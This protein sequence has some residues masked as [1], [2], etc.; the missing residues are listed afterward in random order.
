MPDLLARFKEGFIAGWRALRAPRRSLA[1]A[2]RQLWAV[3]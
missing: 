1:A 2:L 3:Y